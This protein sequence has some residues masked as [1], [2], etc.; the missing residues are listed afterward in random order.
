M[1]QG[2]K[3]LSEHGEGYDYEVEKDGKVIFI[4]VK[5]LS[6]D[7]DDITLTEKETR[8][9]LDERENYWVMVVAR[10]PNSPEIY[11]VKDPASEIDKIV[12]PKSRIKQGEKWD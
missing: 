9:A 5:G 8:K 4:E 2:Y 1:R 3:I 6:S 11:I 7:V 10:I 12:T